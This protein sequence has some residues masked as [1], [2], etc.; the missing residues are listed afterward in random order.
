MAR[1]SIL[2]DG[3]HPVLGEVVWWP[4]CPRPESSEV[5]SLLH[6][7]VSLYVKWGQCGYPHNKGCSG[8]QSGSFLLRAYGAC[9]VTFN[10]FPLCWA[11]LLGTV[12][13]FQVSINKAA[14]NTCDFT[15]SEIFPKDT[16]LEVETLSHKAHSCFPEGVF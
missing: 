9:S 6:A 3:P 12:V 8:G 4:R 14:V 13:S 15:C 10:C 11:W 7:P 5:P 1:P 2:L 16:F